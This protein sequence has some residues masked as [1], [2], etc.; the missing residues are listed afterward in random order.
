M[1]ERPFGAGGR[2]AHASHENICQKTGA[3]IKCSVTRSALRPPKGRALS[4][5]Q[6]DRF[7]TLQIETCRLAIS[8]PRQPSRQDRPLQPPHPP[9]QTDNR[10]P[11]HFRPVGASPSRPVSRM[12]LPEAP[13][14]DD[15]FSFPGPSPTEPTASTLGDLNP[16]HRPGSTAALN[17]IRSDLTPRA[18]SQPLSLSA[19]HPHTLTP[20]HPHTLTPSHPHTLTPSHPHTLTPSHPHTLTRIML[21]VNAVS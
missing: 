15:G 14:P 16:R 9:R 1:C 7:G 10:S 4:F 17:R 18:A 19:S 20:S 12:H 5:R 13:Q 8:G 6:V 2:L 11:R 3:T 21:N